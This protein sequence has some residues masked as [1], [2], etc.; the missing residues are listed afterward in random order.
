MLSK[1]VSESIFE[2]ENYERDRDTN[3]KTKKKD[4]IG[5]EHHSRT[6]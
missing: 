2:R 5:F 4:F 6:T 1:N 3:G